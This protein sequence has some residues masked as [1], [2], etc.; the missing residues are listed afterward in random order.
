MGDE[1]LS[2]L[3]LNIEILVS[4]LLSPISKETANAEA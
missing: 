1:V 2:Q 4:A 3:C